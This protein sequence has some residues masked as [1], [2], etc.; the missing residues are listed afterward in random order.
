MIA[1]ISNIQIDL[2]LWEMIE[3]EKVK[4]SAGIRTHASADIPNIK[5][6]F[7]KYQFWKKTLLA[8]AGFE[9]APTNRLVP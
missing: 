8:A 7:M 6:D 1:L 3:R 2:R 5:K 4:K 9:P